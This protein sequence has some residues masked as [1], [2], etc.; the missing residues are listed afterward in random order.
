[1]TIDDY[2][3]AINSD[4]VFSLTND[5]SLWLLILE[6]A[7][8]KLNG[9]YLSL[10]GGFAHEALQDLTGCPTLVYDMTSQSVEYTYQSN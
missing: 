2:F 6:K 10:R 3:P 5:N 8:A 4:V 9:S 1:V 7:F